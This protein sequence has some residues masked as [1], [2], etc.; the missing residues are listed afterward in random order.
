MFIICLAY[1]VQNENIANALS[2][3]RCKNF[4]SDSNP[5]HFLMQNPAIE[6]YTGGYYVWIFLFSIPVY[7]LWGIIGPIVLFRKV[8]R[9][10]S[11]PNE[12]LKYF[13]LFCG[14]KPEYYYWEF[15][16]LIRKNIIIL[17]LMLFN[18]TKLGG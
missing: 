10:K 8:K 2:L 16:I 15:V 1:L 13:Y 7:L 11:N 4:G 3:F 12:R 17:I 18:F 14:F 9:A 5:H 6:C